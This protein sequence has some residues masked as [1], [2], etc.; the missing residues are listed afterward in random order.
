MMRATL[1]ALVT[2]VTCLHVPHAGAL[3][4]A[5]EDGAYL[6]QAQAQRVALAAPWNAGAYLATTTRAEVQFTRDV[7]AC[8]AR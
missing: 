1:V 8:R 4:A 6:R 7:Q 2:A 3:R 5:C